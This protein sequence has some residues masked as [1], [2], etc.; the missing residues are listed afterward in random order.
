[1]TTQQ[2]APGTPTSSESSEDCHWVGYVDVDDTD[3]LFNPPVQE[4]GAPESLKARTSSADG[5][6]PSTSDH[7]ASAGAS[8]CMRCCN[9][10]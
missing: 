7:S 10:L 5:G 2:T 8:G 6:R 3:D 9:A 4:A 1:M